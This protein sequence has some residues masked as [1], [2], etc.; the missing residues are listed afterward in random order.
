MNI[1]QVNIETKGV[2]GTGLGGVAG[3][4]GGRSITVVTGTLQEAMS[5]ARTKITDKEYVQGV[6]ET[7]KDA[8]VDYSQVTGQNC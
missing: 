3:S 5:I 8:V 2:A 7:A 4:Y 1:Y 6:W